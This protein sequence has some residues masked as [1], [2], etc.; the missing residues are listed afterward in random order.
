MPKKVMFGTKT[1]VTLALLVAL[2]I[3]LTRILAVNA[4][5]YRLSIGSMP[6][7]LSGLLFGPIAGAMVGFVADFLGASLMG[8]AAYMPALMVTPILMGFLPGILRLILKNRNQINVAKLIG[9][10]ENTFS[11]SIP[12]LLIVTAP[13]YIL[14]SMLYTTYILSGM[15]NTPF[16]ALFPMRVLIYVGTMLLDTLLIF[17]LIKSGVFRALGYSF[18]GG[19][20][21]ELRGNAKV[22][23]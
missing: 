2:S 10:T 19:K 1:I 23:S 20:N 11:V 21:N 7:V 18:A 15:Y 22:H 14:G 13:S 17:L 16:M 5:P 3:V 6:I 4:G 9:V 12:K 8:T